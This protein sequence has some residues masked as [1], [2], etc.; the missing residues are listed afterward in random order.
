MEQL[1]VLKCMLITEGDDD[2]ELIMTVLF[3]LP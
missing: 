1:E 3:S 2:D